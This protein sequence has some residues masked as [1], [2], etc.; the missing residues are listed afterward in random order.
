MGDK[1]VTFVDLTLSDETENFIDGPE[2]GGT[3]STMSGAGYLLYQ[4]F[5][6]GILVLASCIYL[7]Q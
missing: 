3:A 5:T 7:W 4:A 2:L 1:T 6:T